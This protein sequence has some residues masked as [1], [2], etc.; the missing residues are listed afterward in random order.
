M[1]GTVLWQGLGRTLDDPGRIRRA[2]NFILSLPM[3]KIRMHQRACLA[4]LF[5]RKDATFEVLP[6]AKI[7]RFVSLSTRFL[8]QEKGGKYTQPFVYSLLLAGGL[9]R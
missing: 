5:S 7:D 2:V 1:S 6:R 8:R 3:P 9:L 4:F